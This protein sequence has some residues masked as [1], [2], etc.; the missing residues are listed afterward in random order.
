MENLCRPAPNRSNQGPLNESGVGSPSC[1]DR[2][3]LHHLSPVLCSRQHGRNKQT[4]LRRQSENPAGVRARCERG[5]D[6]P[7]PCLRQAGRRSIPAPPIRQ[8]TD[9]S[10]KKSGEESA[11]PMMAF[12][13]VAPIYDRRLLQEER[14][15]DHRS[16]LQQESE[17]VY[18]EIVERG[19][20]K[21][22]DLMQ[23]LL[24]FLG[25]NDVR[26]RVPQP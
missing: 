13:A 5:P 4:L 22:A 1:V 9:S 15:G 18:R 25:R 3:V 7:R 10:S 2:P 26:L 11:A 20:R 6:L 17:A 24:A 12:E 19:P 23:A 14:T 16:P 21:L 8:P